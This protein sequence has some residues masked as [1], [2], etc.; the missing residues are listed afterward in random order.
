ME[1]PQ[2]SIRCPKSIVDAIDRIIATKR[3]ASP[4]YRSRYTRTEVIVE[5]L[6][7]ALTARATAPIDPQGA[8]ALGQLNDILK[9]KTTDA[10]EFREAFDNREAPKKKRAKTNGGGKRPLRAVKRK[11]ARRTG[12][13]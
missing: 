11:A 5:L 2:F 7:E 3:A 4:Y 6:G 10:P 1:T 8:E 13:R 12:S 9:V